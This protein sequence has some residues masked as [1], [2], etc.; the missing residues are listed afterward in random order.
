[1]QIAD[2]LILIELQLRGVIGSFAEKTTVSESN[3]PQVSPEVLS[4]AAARS[5]AQSLHPPQLMDSRQGSRKSNPMI[6]SC[7][8]ISQT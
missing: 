1:M 7:R 6:P 5:L 8:L 3:S 4:F 2:E